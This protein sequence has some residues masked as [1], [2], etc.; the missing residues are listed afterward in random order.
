MTRWGGTLVIE[1]GGQVSGTT[2]RVGADNV[3]GRVTVRDTSSTWTNTGVISIGVGSSG[4][5]VLDI[6]GGGRVSNTSGQVG[7]TPGATGT[8]TVS[9]F[10]SQW[11]NSQTL[12][13]GMNGTGF[14]TIDNGGAVSAASTL[15]GMTAAS[16]GTLTLGGT[17]GNRGVLTTSVMQKGLGNGQGGV[18]T[19]NLNG[20]ILRASAD[21]VNFLADKS[22]YSFGFAPGDVVV[23]AGGAF[24]D[25]NGYS[26]GISAALGGAGGLTKLGAGTLTLSGAN[27]YAGGTTIS[28]GVLVA[29]TTSL[30]GPVINN[31]VLVFNQAVDG[32]FSSNISGSGSLTK[33]GSGSLNLTGNNPLTGPTSVQAGQLVVNGSL[34]NSIA[35]VQT[36]A[37]LGGNGT[38]GGLVAQSGG[39]VAPGNSIGRLSVAGNLLFQSGSIYQVEVNAAG[40]ADR[41]D[42]SGTATLQGGN[43]QV[44][45]AQGIYLPRTTYTILSAAGGVSGRFATVTSNLAFLTPTLGYGSTDVTLT[46]ARS[47]DQTPQP[48]AF[49]SVAVT[50]NQFRAAN[51]IEALGEG[52]RVFDTVLGQSAA[53]A[54]QAFD[55]LSGEVHASVA[56][57]AM[58]DARIVQ[59]SIL[60]QLRRPFGY[61]RG[62]TMYSAYA[63]DRPGSPVEPVAIPYPALDPR[64]FALWGEG[65]GSWGKLRSDGNAAAMDT[66]T[67]GFVI[68]ADALL[69]PA[70]RVGIAGG[71]IRTTFDIDSRLSSGS[72]ESVF[73]AL[74][75][76]AVWGAINLRLGASY[77]SHDVDT[78]RT[79]QFPGFG[80][81]LRAS[82][83]GSTVQAFGEMGYRFELARV[84]IEPFVGASVLRLHMDGFAEN[85]GVAA[86]SGYGRSYDLGT[87]TLGVRAE[88]RLSDAVPL[89]LRGM[90]GWRRAFG[91]VNPSALLAF[92]GG[93]SAF[94]VSGTPVDRD[95]LVAE[96]GLDWQATRDIGLG[97][98]YSGQIG[99]RA[100][101]HALK[102]NFTWRF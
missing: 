101:D 4:F 98:A 22:K 23:G 68:G 100:Q 76:S 89:I 88:A 49:N 74:Y 25:S 59:G 27:T 43:V 75:G 20:G 12:S 86:L 82:Y 31:A 15:L 26:I 50:P 60:G 63:A 7:H 2:A 62:A 34:A 80:D 33:I 19:V 96:A 91:D 1:A 51:A 6:L 70:Y 79:V 17:A 36:G 71:F 9:G 54:R 58:A 99:S 85:G 45:A 90:L 29:D 55:A 21:Q 83:G 14:V 95:A 84:Q 47:V 78:R 5:G 37:T 18:V 53:G 56:T 41:I 87:T 46:L 32:T 30:K 42:A 81:A 69:S 65:V 94:S 38:I 13:I 10:G 64:R 66:S 73:G 61:G 35:T 39:F 16:R 52:N 24:I 44:L 28:G 40:Q 97:V 77:A 92:S 57:T 48:I 3:T 72:N 93:A 8:V 102:G 67:G 11:T